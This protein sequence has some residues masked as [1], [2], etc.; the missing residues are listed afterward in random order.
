[1]FQC[2]YTLGLIPF[3]IRAQGIAADAAQSSDLMMGYSLALQPERFHPLL[4]PWMRM[5]IALVVQ[6]LLV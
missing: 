5:M 4:Y 6:R 1:V 3:Q 2:L